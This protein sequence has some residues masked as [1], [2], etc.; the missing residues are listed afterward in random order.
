[1]ADINLTE[2]RQT[3]HRRISSVDDDSTRWTDLRLDDVLALLDE[4]VELEAKVAHLA[5][6]KEAY[7]EQWMLTQAQVARVEALV[8]HDGTV[9]TIDLREALAGGSDG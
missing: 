4:V 1:M 8:D 7:H 3:A 9:F 6:R 5:E 2:L